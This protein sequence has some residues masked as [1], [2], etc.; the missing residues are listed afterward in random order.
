VEWIDIPEPRA[1]DGDVPSVVVRN[2]VATLCGSDVPFF[3]G[4]WPEVSFPAEPTLSLH[5][6]VG[7]VV[8]SES[9]EFEPGQRVLAVPVAHRG[10][11]DR[12][13]TPANQ[14]APL[15]GDRPEE[16]LL[17]CQPLGT[18]Y[19]GCRKLGN[20]IGQ[21]VVIL[22]QGPI[23]LMFS[24]V[25]RRLGARHVIAMDKLDKRLS[26]STKMGATEA[27]NVD[28]EDPV[29]AL[30]RINGG[31]LA[32]L[33]VEAVGHQQ[34]TLNTAIRL[35]APSSTVLCFGLG[36]QK[37]Y[38]VDFAEMYYKNV[39]LINSSGFGMDLTDFIVAMGLIADGFVDVSPLI[40]HRMPIERIQDAYELFT[41]RRDGVI[42][43]ALQFDGQV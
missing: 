31:K 25:V 28:R 2:R 12:F 36:V 41:D 32:D 42:K 26:V 27:I 29:E 9:P 18:V 17:M 20:L 7:E 34:E 6:C 37:H 4:T 19:R 10:L 39:R 30:R 38:T 43:V 8:E 14:V 5:E 3:T 1:V 16:E 11:A 40:T 24:A 13:A 22:G 21:T 35:A 23:G 33:V 15:I